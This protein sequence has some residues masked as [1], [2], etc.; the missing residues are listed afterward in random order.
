MNSC[1]K[2]VN[3]QS[4]NKDEQGIR[5]RIAGV[6]LPKGAGRRLRPFADA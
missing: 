1:G 4:E 2:E 3:N 6:D 5:L